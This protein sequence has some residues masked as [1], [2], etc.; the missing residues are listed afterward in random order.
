MRH[1]SIWIGMFLLCVTQTWAAATLENPAP[2]SLKSGVG[3][4]SGWVCDGEELEISFDGEPRLFVPYGSERSDTAGVCGDTDNGFGLLWNYNELGDGPHTMTLY[5]DGVIVTQVTFNVQTLGT[6]F[7]RGVVGSGTVMLSNGLAVDVQWEETTQGFTIVGYREQT[8]DEEEEDDLPTQQ[9]E[10]D[11][12][13]GD[14]DG[15]EEATAADPHEALWAA[16]HHS[17][18][19]QLQAVLDAGVD[20]D[21]RIGSRGQ[22]A[23]HLVAGFPVH[24]VAERWVRELEEQQA[25]VQDDPEGLARVEERL[26]ELRG[27]TQGATKARLLL[28]AGADV[29]ITDTDWHRQT[30]WLA[31]LDS[32]TRDRRNAGETAFDQEGVTPEEALTELWPERLDV[33]R[34]FLE[35]GSDLDSQDRTGATGL[36]Y[37]ARSHHLPLLRFL[38]EQGA[39]PDLQLISV[40]VDDDGNVRQASAYTPLHFAV[41]GDSYLSH[42]ITIDGIP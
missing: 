28:E 30:P 34:L 11:N 1:F 4:I 20:P 25:L 33:L 5:V 23:L 16:I 12:E 14:P 7:L 26:A 18:P 41:G 3:V 21:L 32:V 37:A 17:D 40:W 29:N 15:T 31:F 8:E 2:G 35:A 13:E 39:D 38:L 42:S 22:T 19:A 36:H 24:S 6:N 10:G 27:R 9:P